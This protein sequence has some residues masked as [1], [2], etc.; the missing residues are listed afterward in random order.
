MAN[1]GKKNSQAAQSAQQPQQGQNAAQPQANQAQAAN[2]GQQ[3][4]PNQQAQSGPK[5]QGQGQAQQTGQSATQAQ[6]QQGQAQQMNQ[7]MAMLQ[8]MQQSQSVTTVPAIPQSQGWWSK[9]SKL[10]AAIMSVL[11][12]ILLIICLGLWMAQIRDSSYRLGF[13]EGK[14]IGYTAGQEFMRSKYSAAPW[15]SRVWS[16]FTG[17]FPE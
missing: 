12:S 9:N 16:G 10:I 4:Q 14:K 11:A 8:N 17:D 13:A 2:Q 1:H 15:Y 5:S 7:I 3:S 6:G